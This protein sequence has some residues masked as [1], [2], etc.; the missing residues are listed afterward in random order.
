MCQILKDLLF[1]EVQNMLTNFDSVNDAVK[2]FN[3]DDCALH[4]GE[5]FALN[6]KEF[7]DYIAEDD[8]QHLFQTSANSS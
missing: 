3:Y 2:S 6:I 5:E 4:H 1:D 7:I 8:M